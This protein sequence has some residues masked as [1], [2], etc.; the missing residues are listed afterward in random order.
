MTVSV[1]YLDKKTKLPTSQCFEV[2]T[3]NHNKLLDAAYSSLCTMTENQ[4]S[5]HW[6]L[7]I[8][9]ILN[10]YLKMLTSHSLFHN[11]LNNH[12]MNFRE[13]TLNF[14]YKNDLFT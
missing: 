10:T 13:R 4:K 5:L 3:Y 8:L 6:Y 2:T 11:N 7:V 12:V 14:V 9:R 1:R